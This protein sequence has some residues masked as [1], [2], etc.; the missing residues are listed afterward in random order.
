MCH[1]SR[2]HSPVSSRLRL[3]AAG[4]VAALTLAACGGVLDE[5][6][7]G[8]SEGNGGEDGG[9][10]NYPERPIE[11]VVPWAAGGGTDQVARTIAQGLG[12]ELG[13][14]VNVVNRTGG[15]GAV[16]HNAMANAD[17]D[18]YTVGMV[19][20]E[21]AMM[22]WMGLADVSVDDLEGI[23]QVNHD[24]AGVTVQADAPWDTIEDFVAHVENNPGDLR[25]SGTGRGGIWD[26]ARAAMLT[27]LGLAEDAIVW[28]PSEGAAP[29]LQQLVA[30]GIDASFASLPENAAMLEADR[31]KA[32][33]I[34]S[35][36]RSER[37]PDVP[38]LAEKDIDVAIGA[39]RGIAVPTDTPDEVKQ[40]L[41]EAVQTVVEGDQ[42][43]SFMEDNGFGIEWRDSADFSSFMSQQDE[44]IG[45]LM[46][47]TGLAEN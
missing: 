16:G 20:V 11:M 18:G 29:A 23:A 31:V 21:I 33:A 15:G 27:E 30:G 2:M 5:G 42:Y 46:R 26:V 34:M 39:W 1:G 36:E 28:V 8:G 7:T 4:V 3:T 14:Q 13:V 25:A 41:Q 22:H 45:Q 44:E 35:D 24:P 38:T 43:R 17:P 19:T 40:A 6:Q 9:A 10:T 12:D 47:D 32:L 37:Y